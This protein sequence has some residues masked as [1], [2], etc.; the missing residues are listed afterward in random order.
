VEDADTVMAYL[1]DWRNAMQ[2]RVSANQAL[3]VFLG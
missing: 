1:A 3:L 2:R